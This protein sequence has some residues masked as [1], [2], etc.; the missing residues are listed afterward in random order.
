MTPISTLTFVGLVIT[1]VLT[2][3]K[4]YFS[5]AARAKEKKEKFEIDNKKFLEMVAV[6]IIKLRESMK[7]EN[8]NVSKV[9]VIIDDKKSGEF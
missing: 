6:S 8:G 3:I 5:A 9:E 1:L 2:I 4:E 7:K